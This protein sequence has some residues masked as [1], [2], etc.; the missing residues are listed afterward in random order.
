MTFYF[1]YKSNHL[2]GPVTSCGTKTKNK[3]TAIVK[4]NHGIVALLTVS[5]FNPVRLQTVNKQIPIGGVTNPKDRR[6]TIKITKKTGSIPTVKTVGIKIG[7]NIKIAAVASINIPT[8][9]KK[10][11]N[12]SIITRG[13]SLT[14]LRNSATFVGKP[15]YENTQLAACAVTAINKIVPDKLVVL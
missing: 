15:S 3:R 10:T 4:I 7:T 11:N 2:I 6:T 8:R 14:P 1:F 5:I 9:R 13:L 12:K